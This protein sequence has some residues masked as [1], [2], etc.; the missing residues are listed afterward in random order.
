MTFGRVVL[1][2]DCQVDSEMTLT[3]SSLRYRSDPGLYFCRR[4]YNDSFTDVTSYDLTVACKWT[5]DEVDW[6]LAV[7]SDETKSSI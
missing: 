3:I 7:A 6:L 1:V 4:T 2:A 5:S